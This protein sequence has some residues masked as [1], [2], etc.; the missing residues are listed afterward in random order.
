MV[1]L[2]D[3]G[4]CAVVVVRAALQKQ[5]VKVDDCLLLLE[6]LVVGLYLSLD[7]LMMEC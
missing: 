1:A 7:E 5:L 2:D 3:Y 4:V 6:L